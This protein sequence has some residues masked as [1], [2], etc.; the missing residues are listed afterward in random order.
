[1]TLD[2]IGTRKWSFIGSGVTALLALIILAIP[3]TFRPG[4][5]FTAG[6]TALIR[7][8]RPVSQED[9]RRAYADLGHDEARIQQTE[10][11]TEYLIRTRELHVPPGSFTEVTPD[12]TATTAPV[13]P[14][15]LTAIG[16]VVMGG[17]PAAAGPLDLLDV[18]RAG[19]C[20]LGTQKLGTAKAGDRVDVVEI[21]HNCS[22]GDLYR[23]LVGDVSGYLAAKDVREYQ[24]KPKEAAPEPDRGERTVIENGLRERF[25]AF[26]VR[27]FASVSATVSRVAVR[28]TAIA[29]VVS[30]LFIMA[31]IAFAFASL[32]RPLRYG[33]CA[34]VA[35]L[36]DVII[37]LGA[38][39]LFSKVFHVEVNLMFVTGL[40]TVIG[41]SVHDTIVVYDRI[42][43]N[44]KQSPHAPFSSNVN[45]AL[46]QTIARSINT[47]TTVLLTVATMLVL[48]G[49]TIASFLLVIF[50]GVA[51]GTYSSIGIASQLLVAWEEGDLARVFGRR[52]DAENQ[53]AG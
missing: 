33:A 38:F 2:L 37:T 36:H 21:L 1:M 8:S 32:P 42:R 14:T 17:T 47:S 6:S 39:S 40:L 44:V 50:V 13:G 28:N 35:L 11:N 15:P 12:A 5:E 34:I 24:E 46:V 48:G 23:V 4:I 27:E 26:E 18:D 29:V 51:A 20:K 45:A 16:T 22:E 52:G 30:T 41:F 25:G 53:P 19:A 31:Y 3:P 9:L 43:E 7:F 10:S 49:T